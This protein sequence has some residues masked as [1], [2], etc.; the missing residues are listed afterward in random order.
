MATWI[1]NHATFAVGNS[2]VSQKIGSVPRLA[3]IKRIVF[4]WRI[5]VV[6]SDQDAIGM[7][8]VYQFGA[9]VTLDSSNEAVIPDP[10]SVPLNEPGWPVQ[11]WLHWEARRMVPRCKTLLGQGSTGTIWSDDGFI[12]EVNREKQVYAN[13]AVGHTLDVWLVLKGANWPPYPSNVDGSYW[14]RVLYE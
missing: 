6:A 3:T 14:A 8:N 12:G 1:T 5:G 11:R 7:N 9:I 13:V 4:N 2:Q 10:T